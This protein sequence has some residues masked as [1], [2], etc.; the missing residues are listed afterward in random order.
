MPRSGPH[1]VFATFHVTPCT[2]SSRGRLR[3][4]SVAVGFIPYSAL[5][6]SDKGCASNPPYK[7]SYYEFGMSEDLETV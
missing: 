7:V 1:V 2:P 3:R 4:P 6:R 5:G